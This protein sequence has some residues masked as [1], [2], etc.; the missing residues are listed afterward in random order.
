MSG[1]QSSSESNPRLELLRSPCKSSSNSADSSFCSVGAGRGREEDGMDRLESMPDT[2]H[3]R[4]ERERDMSQI[5]DLRHNLITT[6]TR[7]VTRGGARNTMYTRYLPPASTTLFL[8]LFPEHRLLFRPLRLDRGMSL[9]ESFVILP[10]L[11]LLLLLLHGGQKP[12][13]LP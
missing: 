3:R 6:S 10:V 7:Y 9:L 13:I 11:L 4:R 8:R 12:R 5:T 2:N 1:T